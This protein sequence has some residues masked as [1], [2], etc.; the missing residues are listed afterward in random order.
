[1][2]APR[3]HRGLLVTLLLAATWASGLADLAD[4]VE[5]A[6]VAKEVSDELGKSAS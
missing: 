2:T 1:M 3:Y 5:D 6:E 4:I